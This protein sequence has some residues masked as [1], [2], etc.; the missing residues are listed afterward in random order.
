ME[1]VPKQ[2]RKKQLR[3]ELND[4]F[5]RHL[6]KEGMDNQFFLTPTDRNIN[7]IYPLPTNA[8]SY[9]DVSN[10]GYIDT[11]GP[12]K[13]KW[14]SAEFK[15]PEDSYNDSKDTISIQESP[16]GYDILFS[17][18]NDKIIGKLSV[19]AN[20]KKKGFIKD[21]TEKPGFRNRRI[22]R[23]LLKYALQF[24]DEIALSMKASEGARKI[25][26]MEKV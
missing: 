10:N 2:L 9:N 1:I 7:P 4:V 18:S 25:W 12:S 24:F 26:D 20:D 3:E 14:P 8:T 16:R 19:S 17:L 11:H 21:F 5:K 6:T 13:A 22:G 23:K 15:L